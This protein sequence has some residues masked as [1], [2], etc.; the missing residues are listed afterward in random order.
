MWIR[1]AERRGAGSGLGSR[2]PRR[3]RIPRGLG[4]PGAGPEGVGLAA[5]AANAPRADQ[6]LVLG[7]W[8]V[9][10]SFFGGYTFNDNVFATHNYRVGLS[11]LQIAPSLEAG[12]DSGL[13]RTN[14]SFGA[15]T[16]IY[17]GTGG[18]TRSNYA[19]GT[20]VNDA[21]PTNVTG[22]LSVSETWMPKADWAVIGSGNF[23]PDL[24][25]QREPLL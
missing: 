18:Q 13:W 3:P 10:P 21:P 14:V 20:T 9:Y 5:Y 23:D 1:R 15:S 4:S 24:V 16:L 6:G 25:R 17:P 8:L 22:H 7:R 19:L 2:L 12:L 11:G